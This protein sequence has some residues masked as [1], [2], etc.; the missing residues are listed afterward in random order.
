MREMLLAYD[1]DALRSLTLPNSAHLSS[2][3]VD[4]GVLL[5]ISGILITIGSW[6]YPNL[7]Q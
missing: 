1:V 4:V 6:V 3:A 7:V 5:L 2:L